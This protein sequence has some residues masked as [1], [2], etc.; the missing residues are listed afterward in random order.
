M[1]D[2]FRI[3][4][5][6]VEEQV[7]GLERMGGKAYGLYVLD[8]NGFQIPETAVIPVGTKFDS[9]ILFQVSNFVKEILDSDS[10]ALFSVRSSGC[11]EDGHQTSFAGMYETYLNVKQEDIEEAIR[12][13]YQSAHSNRVESYGELMGIKKE[14]QK[15]MA[16]VIQK[17]VCADMSGVMFT[18]NPIDG[19]QSEVIIEAVNGLGEK[20]VSGQITPDY[21]CISKENGELLE[22]EPGDE[23]GMHLEKKVYETMRLDAKKLVMCFASEMDIEFS[24]ENGNIVYLQA[25]SITSI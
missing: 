4:G 16:I 7:A 23:D 21:Y 8:K 10:N 13:C 25:R 2:R 5:N 20:L 17:M 18:S 1:K 6:Q 12:K 9:Q 3:L 19:N 14:E 22:F 11:M 24:V 15:R